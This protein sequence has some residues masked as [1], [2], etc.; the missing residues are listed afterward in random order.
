MQLFVGFQVLPVYRLHSWEL[1]HMLVQHLLL[2]DEEV[3]RRHLHVTAQL[4]PHLVLY[5]L[6]LLPNTLLFF[7]FVLVHVLQEFVPALV[8]NILHYLPPD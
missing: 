8:I 3:G 7:D 2:A 6:Y 5:R 1:N 4:I